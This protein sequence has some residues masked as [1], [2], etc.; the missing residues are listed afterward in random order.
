MEKLKCNKC[1]KKFDSNGTSGMCSDCRRKSHTQF[2]F[3]IALV[4]LLL[5]FIS[6]IALGDTYKITKLTYES[7]ISVKFNEYET[8]FN[9]DLMLYCWVGTLLFDLFVFAINSICYRLDL[10]IDRLK[11]NSNI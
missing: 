7:S 10:I 1:G 3:Y 6:G 9:S 11:D 4:I 8:S 5:G 2:Y